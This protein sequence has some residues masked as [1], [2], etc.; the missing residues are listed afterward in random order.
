MTS[1]AFIAKWKDN[2]LYAGAGSRPLLCNLCTILGGNLPNTDDSYFFGRGVT[3]TDAEHGWTARTFRVGTQD[4]ASDLSVEPKQLMTSAVAL[5][6][7]ANLV[8]SMMC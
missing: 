2:P 5:E 7:S 3:R 4:R 1:A 8:T 6:N